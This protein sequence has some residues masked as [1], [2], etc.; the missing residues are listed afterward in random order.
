[1]SVKRIRLTPRKRPVQARSHFTVDAILIATGRVLLSDG[2]EAMTTNRVAEVAGV[3]VGSLYQYFPGKESL[4]A[5]LFVRQREEQL[6]AF[7]MKLVERA[8]EPLPVIARAIAEAFVE[9][10]AVDPK[11]YVA[12]LELADHL[13]AWRKTLEIDD[14]AIRLMVDLLD[15]RSDEM[16]RANPE[17][18]A[19]MSIT[20]ADRV[21]R[22]AAIRQPQLLEDG[23]VTDE[24]TAALLGYLK[25]G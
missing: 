15:E 1:V 22:D 11:L 17:V 8:L 2:F 18:A 6:E 7:T 25:P 12:V 9:H 14:D 4:V 5:S 21:V 23:T 13:G 10:Y 3:S 19:W 24:L 20:M 16:G